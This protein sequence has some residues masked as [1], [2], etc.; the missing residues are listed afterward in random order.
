MRKF[1]SIIG[2]MSLILVSFIYTEKIANMVIDKDKLMMTIKEESKIYEIETVEAIINNNN[3]IIP[4]INGL[5]VNNKESYKQM[6]K[7]GIFNNNL[8]EFSEVSP[9]HK[10]KDN[11]DKY[12][13]SGNKE[14]NAVSL[15]F[16][17]YENS[18]LDSI[19]NIL[20]EKNIK[21]NFFVD[22][23]WFEKNNDRVY[24]LIN[25]GYVIGN[26]SYNQNYNDSAFV[27]MDTILKRV[28]KQKQGFCYAE[29]ENSEF[30]EIC[31]LN[32]N[33]TIK[34]SLI[35]KNNYYQNIKENLVSGSIIS[36]EINSSL[37]QELPIIINYIHS[38]GYKIENLTELL[39]EK[40]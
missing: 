22:G 5:K 16:L 26:L 25:N 1:F 31:S 40:R 7:Y 9:K 10:L 6:K 30:L 27:W 12:V 3:T 13:I 38:K 37:K 11:Y 23:Y 17:V 29:T 33:I 35:L 14:K 2:F 36:L 32:K 21:A 8:L 28:G 39:S 34:P 15:I 24:E 18:D 20:K 4:G 19:I